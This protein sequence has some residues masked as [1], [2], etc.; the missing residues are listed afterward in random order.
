M[1]DK[2]KILLNFTQNDSFGSIINNSNYKEE[3]GKMLDSLESLSPISV[4]IANAEFVEKHAE[5]MEYIDSLNSGKI[6]LLYDGDYVIPHTKYNHKGGS[7]FRIVE[8]DTSRPW[9]ID[10]SNDFGFEV[11]KYFN[12]SDSKYNFYKPVGEAL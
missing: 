6:A 9:C 8:V 3:Y 5:K 1:S 2:I 7:K 4:R 11:V 12:P 10:V